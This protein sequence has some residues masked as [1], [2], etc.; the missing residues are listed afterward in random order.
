MPR[1]QKAS[2]RVP[3]KSFAL[4]VRL[5]HPDRVLFETPMITKQDLAVYYASVVEWMLPH[6]SGRPLAIVRCPAGTSEPCFFQKHPPAG[7]PDT[8]N[9]IS[10]QEKDKAATYLEIDD[11]TGLL[12][13]VQH[14]VIELHTW[15]ARCDDVE[16]PD[17]LVFDLDPDPTVVWKE[18]VSSAFLLRR[19][20]EDIGLTTFVKTTGGKGLHVAVPTRPIQEWPA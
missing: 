16:L 11:V 13:L 15:G 5:T 17:R 3:S 6:V 14:G 1:T 18:L 12:A 10:I 2:R 8:V 4:N 9:R 19:N 20:F 7:L